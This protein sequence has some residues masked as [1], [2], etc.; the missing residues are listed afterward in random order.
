MGNLTAP[1]VLSEHKRSQG[2]TE[3]ASFATAAQHS[4]VLQ[5]LRNE[6][7][8]LLSEFHCIFHGSAQRNTNERRAL[9]ASFDGQL[10]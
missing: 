6:E 10:G 1:D 7:T 8:A 4:E 9:T 2:Q 5:S 3:S